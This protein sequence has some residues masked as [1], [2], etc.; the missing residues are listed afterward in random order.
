[1]NPNTRL[2][3]K[4]V[5]AS[6]AS[7]TYTLLPSGKAITCE[8]ILNTGWVCHGT[9]AVVDLDNYD[10][11]RGKEAAKVKAMQQVWDYHAVCMQEAMFHGQQDGTLPNRNAE[12]MNGH[13]YLHDGR[14]VLV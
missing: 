9:A 6:V 5:E 8:I 12:M 7:T 10:E 11:Q 1:M 3:F 4:I 13:Q 2:D 14:P